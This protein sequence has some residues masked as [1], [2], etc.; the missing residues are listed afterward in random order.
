MHVTK[1]KLLDIACDEIYH[2][3]YHSTSI[4]KILEKSDTSKSSFYYHFK[5]KKELI[6]AVINQ[7]IYSGINSEYGLLLDVEKNFIDEILIAIKNENNFNFKY[8]CKLNN[9]VQELTNKDEIFK[10]SL[11][12]TYLMFE[13]IFEE[14]LNKAVKNQEI[15]EVDT[16]ELSMYIVASIEGCLSTAKK[17]QNH[18]LYY[19][20]ISHLEKYLNSY[21]IV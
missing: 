5:S 3:G 2:N 21:R 19:S 7:N 14:V 18:K 9:L 4:D 13:N 1:K 12:K 10:V 16:K 11:E 17:S 15:I 8:G 6:E 20:C